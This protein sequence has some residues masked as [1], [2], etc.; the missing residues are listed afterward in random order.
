MEC[1]QAQLVC[2]L[3]DYH[4]DSQNWL[5]PRNFKKGHLGRWVGL[6]Q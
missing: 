4:N 3:V 1:P 6:Y 5:S 2:L